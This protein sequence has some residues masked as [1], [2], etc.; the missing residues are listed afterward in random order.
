MRP[1][2]RVA[3]TI[4]EMLIIETLRVM[5]TRTV[6]YIILMASKELKYRKGNRDKR[7]KPSYW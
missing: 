5:S 6:K 1:N 7:D 4:D 3:Y 2:G